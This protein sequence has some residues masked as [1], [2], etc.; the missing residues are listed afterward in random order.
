MNETMTKYKESLKDKK[1]CTKEEIKC[2][3]NKLTK[4]ME[5]GR[6]VEYNQ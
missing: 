6:L 1:A 5:E 4:L 2:H 3:V